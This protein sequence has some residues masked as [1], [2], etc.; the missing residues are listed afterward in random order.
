MQVVVRMAES[1]NSECVV[2]SLLPLLVGVVVLLL[3]C[4]SC[5]GDNV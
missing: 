3:V 2:R 4:P 5:A 1:F